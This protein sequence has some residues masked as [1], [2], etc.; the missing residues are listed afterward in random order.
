MKRYLYLLSMVIVLG[1]CSGIPKNLSSYTAFGQIEGRVSIGEQAYPMILD[2]L[3][4]KEKNMEVSKIPESDIYVSA[5]EFPTLEVS[6]EDKITIDIDQSPSSIKVTQYN[7]DG[8]SKEVSIIDNQIQVPIEEG[9][10][11]YEVQATW[12]QGEYTFLFD[13]ERNDS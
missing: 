1:A 5:E 4:W 8:T 6:K 3:E 7:E 13:I 12:S 9:H 10:Y 11:I 2:Q